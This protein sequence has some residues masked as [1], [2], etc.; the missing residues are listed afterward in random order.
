MSET[1]KDGDSVILKLEYEARAFWSEDLG[2]WVLDRE[3]KLDSFWPNSSAIKEI[4]RP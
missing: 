4:I 3:R 2:R 1:P